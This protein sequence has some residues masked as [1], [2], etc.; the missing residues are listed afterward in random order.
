MIEIG[1]FHMDLLV[2]VH[3]LQAGMVLSRPVKR[4]AQLL[5]PDGREVSLQDISRLQKWGVEQVYVQSRELAS[6]S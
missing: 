3:E 5:Y 4:D 6:L 1:E 2:D